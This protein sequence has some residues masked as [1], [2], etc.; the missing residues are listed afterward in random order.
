VTLLDIGRGWGSMAMHA[1]GH[2]DAEV[3]AVTTALE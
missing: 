3:V 1:A 2:H